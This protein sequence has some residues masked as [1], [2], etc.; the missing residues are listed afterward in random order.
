[1]AS[2]FAGA[3]V[4]TAGA[5]GQGRI[6]HGCRWRLRLIHEAIR[7]IDDAD[8]CHVSPSALE[9]RVDKLEN[10]NDLSAAAGRRGTFKPVIGKSER[11]L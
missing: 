2:D 6:L 5:C 3:F 1:V 9:R 7:E 10:T 11:K 8:E 4:A